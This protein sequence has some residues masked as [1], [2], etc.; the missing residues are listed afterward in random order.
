M[1]ARCGSW[2]YLDFRKAQYLDFREQQFNSLCLSMSDA[3]H[4][5]L[6]LLHIHCHEEILVTGLSGKLLKLC[7]CCMG[8]GGG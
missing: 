6:P 1:V 2:D 4:W 3:P 5:S 7:A 8:G